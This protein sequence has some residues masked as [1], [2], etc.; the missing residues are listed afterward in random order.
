MIPP[1]L[2]DDVSNEKNLSL[3]KQG[4]I[5]CKPSNQTVKSLMAWICAVWKGEYNTILDILEEYPMLKCTSYV[6]QN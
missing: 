3:L 5:K 1:T 4:V 2:D 6:S